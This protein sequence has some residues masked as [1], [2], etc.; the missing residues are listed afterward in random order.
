MRFLSPLTVVLAALVGSVFV[1]EPAEAR[2]FYPEQGVMCQ[3]RTQI[4]Y[5]NGAP[6]IA[7]TRRYFGRDAA[8]AIGRDLRRGDVFRPERG[9]V[10]RRRL[11]ECEDRFGPNVGLTRI[12]FGR[13]AARRLARRLE[14]Y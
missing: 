10:C 11:Q 8:E 13:D 12:Y 14:R 5:R 3:S 9:V 6:S 7:A 4:C 1:T 2:R